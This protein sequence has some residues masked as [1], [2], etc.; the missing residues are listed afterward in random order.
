MDLIPYIYHEQQEGALCAQHALN[1]LLQGEY[2]TAVDLANIAHEL[3]EE[4]AA[5][6]SNQNQVKIMMIPVFFQYK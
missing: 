1:S 4:E 6:D 2:F 5:L 3:D